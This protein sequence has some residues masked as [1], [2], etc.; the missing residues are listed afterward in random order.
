[1]DSLLKA[2]G[3][4]LPKP[5]ENRVTKIVKLALLSAVI[6]LGIVSSQAVMPG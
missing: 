6:L 5:D 2:L 1:M 3:F 4:L